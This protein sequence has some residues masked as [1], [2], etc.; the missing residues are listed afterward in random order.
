[1]A[2]AGRDR[3]RDRDRVPRTAAGDSNG[4][5]GY[6]GRGARSE[7]SM[8]H[9]TFGFMAPC[10]RLLE[11]AKAYMDEVGWLV[12]NFGGELCDL[13]VSWPHFLVACGLWKSR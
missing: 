9:D 3:E 10:W 8:D 6:E 1:M 5:A 12:G 7:A 11:R 13:A 4:Y 2:D